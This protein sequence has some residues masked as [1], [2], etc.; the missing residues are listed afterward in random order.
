MLPCS[1]FIPGS[2]LIGCLWTRDLVF[3][4]FS[5]ATRRHFIHFPQMLMLFLCWLST[6]CDASPSHYLGVIASYLL[7][8]GYFHHLGLVAGRLGYF[9]APRLSI[10]SAFIFLLHAHSNP[11]RLYILS[12]DFRFSMLSPKLVD[13]PLLSSRPRI[14]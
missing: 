1:M 7:S 4:N 10:T 5:S 11:P 14:H 2:L 12:V 13:D 9:F 3:A 6:P 8:V